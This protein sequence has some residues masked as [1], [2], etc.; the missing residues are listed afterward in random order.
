METEI[1]IEETVKQKD[2]F[3]SLFTNKDRSIIIMADE[4][5]TE[6]TFSGMIVH[7]ANKGKSGALGTYST[8]WTYQQFT[9]LPK[10]SV[11]QLTVRQED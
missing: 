8:G 11:I 6:K 5:T 4:R 2:Y 10:G 1:K 7:S 3:P 9:R